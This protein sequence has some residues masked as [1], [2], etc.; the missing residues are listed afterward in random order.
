MGFANLLE[1]Q[2]V[3]AQGK[4]DYEVSTS[5]FTLYD[6]ANKT[7]LHPIFS[8]ISESYDDDVRCV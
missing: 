2:A 5:P 8:Y 4:F 1:D 3:I 7:S 6:R